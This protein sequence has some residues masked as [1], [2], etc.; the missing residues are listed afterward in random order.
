MISFRAVSPSFVLHKTVTTKNK[1]QTIITNFTPP[2]NPPAIL[3]TPQITGSPAIR[4]VA[5]VI[6]LMNKVASINEIKKEIPFTTICARYP[7]T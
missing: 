3:F 5:Q 1:I 4:F 6:H 7:T 2:S